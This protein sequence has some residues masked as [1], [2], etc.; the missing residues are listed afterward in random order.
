MWWGVVG[1]VG[2]DILQTSTRKNRISPDFLFWGYF[3]LFSGRDLFRDL[4]RLIF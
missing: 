1:I 2:V 3:F 4:V